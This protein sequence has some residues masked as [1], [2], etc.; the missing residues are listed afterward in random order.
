MHC[1]HPTV[2]VGKQT[3]Y[4]F[5]KEYELRTAVTYARQLAKLRESFGRYEGIKGPS[6]LSKWLNIPEN[7]IL[8]YMHLCLQGTFQAIFMNF[9]D[10]KRHSKRYYL[11]N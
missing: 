8:D 7:V 2:R 6:H 4:P 1:L 11:G 5:V 9:F 10:S 3:F